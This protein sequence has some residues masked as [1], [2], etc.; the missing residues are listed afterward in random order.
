M[1]FP[2]SR[3]LHAFPAVV[4]VL[5]A[6][7]QW[8]YTS[9]EASVVFS[10]ARTIVDGYGPALQPGAIWSHGFSSTLWLLL[11]TGAELLGLPLYH[12]AKGLGLGLGVL[13]LLLLPSVS[14][15]LRGRDRAG[16]Q[17][18]LPP[19]LLALHPTVAR[20]V[21][22]GLESSLTL[23]LLALALRLF[24]AEERRFGE[25]SPRPLELWSAVPL[26]LLLLNRPEAPVWF[27]ALACWRLLGRIT[28]GRLPPATVAWLLLPPLVYG[29]TLVGS[30]L[31]FADPWPGV[32]TSRTALQETTIGDPLAVKQG[33]QSLAGTPGQWG[34]AIPLVVLALLG[35]LRS[36]NYWGRMALLG[37]AVC[38][39]AVVVMI[40]GDPSGRLLLPTLMAGSVLAAEGLGSLMRRLPGAGRLR[41]LTGAALLVGM[42]LWPC[43]SGV[44]SMLGPRPETRMDIRQ[45]V[46][47]LDELVS[48]LGFHA[49]QVRLLTTDPG[50]GALHGFQVV[51]ASGLT[52]P[53]IRRF[54]DRQHSLE[55]QQLIFRQR[56]PQIIVEHGLWR[57]MQALGS[58]PEARRLYAT[59]NLPQFP[60]YRVS[61]S[62]ELLLE[63]EPLGDTRLHGDAGD[64]LTL[65]G[66]RAEPGH[67]VL[68]WTARRKLHSRRRAVLRLGRRLTRAIQ[69][70]PS[71]YPTTRWRPGEVVRQRLP[72]PATLPAQMLP[73]SISRDGRWNQLGHVDG[74]RFGQSWKQWF[75]QQAQLLANSGQQ[76]LLELIPLLS[77]RPTV[78]V[79]RVARHIMFR[80][81]KL[82]RGRMLVRAAR[83]LRLI[84]FMTN[85]NPEVRELARQLA[86]AAFAQAQEQA[87]RSSWAS[88]FA[89]LGAAAM[90]NPGDPW[91]ARRQSE[92]RRRLPAGSHLVE[93]LELELAQRAM[94]LSPASVSNL[95][96]LLRAYLALEQYVEAIAAYLTWRRQG[97]RPPEHAMLVAEAMF[98]LG[99]LQRAIEM[100]A[101]PRGI[102]IERLRCP[103]EH[104]IRTSFL[105]D[106]VQRKLGHGPQPSA[107]ERAAAGKGMAL[108]PGA[109]LLAHCSHWAPGKPLTVDLFILQKAPVPLELQLFCG[110]RRQRLTL[111]PAVQRL[112]RVT[113]KFSLPPASYKLR[114]RAGRGPMLEMG[115]VV[116][117]P[118]ST[119]GFELPRYA[120][121]IRQGTA[122]GRGPVAARGLR[123]R[124]IFGHVGAGFADS[125]ATGS[126][127]A[128]GQIKSPAFLIRK[129]YLMLLVAGGDDPALAVELVVA[130]QR[131]AV[132]RGRRSEVMRAVFLPVARYRGL[133]ARVVVRDHDSKHWGH[134]AV[135]E[136]R[137]LDGPAPGIAP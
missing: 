37:L 19:L 119:F 92:A 124:R 93:V 105:H 118:E 41:L 130:G 112:R 18:L 131:V 64:G 134:I 79:D 32:I 120:A 116:V 123:Y 43:V 96:R 48:R 108:S 78:Q 128:V 122:F 85:H 45:L 67:L 46:V 50:V 51:D 90:A 44:R 20:H 129:E 33:W 30:Y 9:N 22:G 38:N 109:V 101:L 29:A 115:T 15:R 99:W 40:G 125:F 2:R 54:N 34:A 121:W 42:L 91:I 3:P 49:A 106:D 8:Q 110:P 55:L 97:P 74:R 86:R 39:L 102:R 98:Q 53:A 6:L 113:K 47:R 100:S 36:F 59:I 10:Y 111:P 7:V 72:V 76:D 94:A 23:L 82:M 133:R 73:L 65:V 63:P 104:L 11:L 80:T 31:L 103:S 17:D 62:R 114:L 132:V 27:L 107:L 52:D 117:G 12:T 1:S 58:Y 68:L 28:A 35:S 14:A 71:V 126:D 69:I 26:C 66:Q 87:R 4:L 83:Q 88:A 70:G 21:V 13:A 75:K 136:I 57:Y 60:G 135:D 56:R 25:G 16:L 95:S 77:H 61:I 5:H 81:R 84:Q 137:Q 127:R 24:V 89:T